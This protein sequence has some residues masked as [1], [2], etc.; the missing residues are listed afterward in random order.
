LLVIANLELV[1]KLQIAVIYNPVKNRLGSSHIIAL[2]R[3]L[4]LKLDLI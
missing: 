2:I 1:V 4:K 3:G